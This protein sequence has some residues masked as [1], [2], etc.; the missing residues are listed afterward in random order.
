MTEYCLDTYALVEI[1]YGNIKFSKYIQEQFLIPDWTLGEFYYV[2]MKKYGEE[3]ADALIKKM[4]NHSISVSKEIILK[5]MKFRYKFKQKNRSNISFFDAIGY[6][7]ARENNLMF[8]TGDK[9]FEG[10]ES[11]EFIKK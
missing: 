1:A 6:I 4:E 5:S 3:E 9:E 7:F 2:W 10:L 8:V 11:V